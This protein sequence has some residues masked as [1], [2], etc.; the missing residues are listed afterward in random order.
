[1]RHWIIANGQE[2]DLDISPIEKKF[3]DY[4][5]IYVLQLARENINRVN[6]GSPAYL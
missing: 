2:K 4:R 6:P 5:K 1:M 3:I